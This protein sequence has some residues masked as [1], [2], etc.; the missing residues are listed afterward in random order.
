MISS[1]NMTKSDDFVRLLNK[2]WRRS[3]IFIVNF[4]H[5]SDLFL[6]FILLTLNRWMLTGYPVAVV[7]KPSFFTK[8]MFLSK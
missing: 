5:I 7:F 8:W 3:D 4:E 6:V 2:S 1:V